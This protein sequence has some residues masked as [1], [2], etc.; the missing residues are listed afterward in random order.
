MLPNY[1]KLPC[2][3]V[4][5]I[6]VGELRKY[7][8][9][10]AEQYDRYA[11]N[12]ERISWLRLGALKSMI[13]SE[14]INSLLDVGYGNGYFLKACAQAGIDC[15]GYDITGY[16]VPE[17]KIINDP[18]VKVDV[19]TFYDSLEH[20]PDPAGF[21][22]KLQ[23]RHICIS[24]PCAYNVESDDWFRNWK[25]R[26]PDEHLWHWNATSLT[27]YMCKLSFYPSC[28][29]YPEDLIRKPEK[30]YSRNILTMLFVNANS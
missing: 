16:P 13:G 4:H 10:Y 14:P 7:D 28:I 15:F 25:H 12:N 29:G 3:T 5:Q 27:R 9:K 19:V 8:L 21:I 17:A 11:E 18:T 30:P 22:R 2:G 1:E 26:R 23:T 20:M 6:Q 24:V